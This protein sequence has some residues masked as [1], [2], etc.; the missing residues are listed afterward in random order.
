MAKAPEI[1]GGL[2]FANYFLCGH[3]AQQQGR[4]MPD[5]SLEM[6]LP[7]RMPR[8]SASFPDVTQQIHSL[9]A[10]GVTTAHVAA[11]FASALMAFLKSGGRV[12]IG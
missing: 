5:L 4:R 10:S 2:F 12:C 1:L 3:P 8:V 11:A 7:M 6:A 9:R